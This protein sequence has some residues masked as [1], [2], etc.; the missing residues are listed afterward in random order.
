MTDF[1]NKT[2]FLKALQRNGNLAS[3]AERTQ[4]G[5]QQKPVFTAAKRLQEAALYIHMV[6]YTWL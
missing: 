6:Y 2:F 1:Y 4:I 5:A 3:A